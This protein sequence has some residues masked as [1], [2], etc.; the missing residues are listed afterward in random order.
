MIRYA[1]RGL[2][3]SPGFTSI[4]ILTLAA[5]IGANTAVFTV[6]NALLLRPLPLAGVAF[7]TTGEG[8]A[9]FGPVENGAVGTGAKLGLFGSS[10]C[11]R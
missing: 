10:L 7:A 2:L 4:A 11:F 9:G 1:L 3:K 8:V 5:G 6:A